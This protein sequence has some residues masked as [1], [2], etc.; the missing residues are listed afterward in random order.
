[1]KKLITTSIIAVLVSFVTTVFS[2]NYPEEYLGL[3][4]DN[5]NLYAVMKL[6]RESKTL[7]D[8]ERGLNDENSRIN[9]LDLNGDNLIDYITVTDYVDGNVHTIVLRA[10]LDRNESQDV[11]IFTVEKFRNGSVEIQLI[12]DEAL[13]GRNY[14][15][16]PIYDETPNPG[17]MGNRASTTNVTLVRTT[18][19]Q[20][21]TW[22]VIRF[23][24][25]PNYVVWRSSWYWGY[26]PVSWR[27]WRP[28]YWHYYYG[29]HYNWYHD[30]YVHYRFWSR[31]RY[32]NYN[33]YYISIRTQSPRVYS[34]I[35]EG[36][37]RETYSRPE[38]R[39]EGEI[40]FTKMHPTQ[41]RRTAENTPVVRNLNSSRERNGEVAKQGTSVQSR[42]NVTTRERTT[43]RNIGT[44][45][46]TTTTARDRTQER[47]TSQNP[48][49]STRSTT[50][51]AERNRDLATGKNTGTAT[52]TTTARDRTQERTT[53]QNPGTTTRTTTARERTQERT[54]SQNPGI[55]TRST[56]ATAERNRDLATGRN[57]GTTARST[58]TRVERERST[59]VAQNKPS[60]K[61]TIAAKPERS[62][63]TQAPKASSKQSS[64]RIESR[65]NA[66]TSSRVNSE[67]RKR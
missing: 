43:D 29:Y 57:T 25:M 56:T 54:T 20:V 65:Q 4:G 23:I 18:T 51:T 11:A 40:L 12:G 59:S 5:L 34:R 9:N 6:F 16:E 61:T 3:P 17:Y 28:Y 33:T 47:T 32:T 10:L 27:P 1:M 35:K 60:T 46:R 67:T 21:A 66:N 26:Y 37:Y 38:Q 39:R 55:S 22:P 44:S 53:S 31:P 58:T 48:G 50:A 45:T 52:R 8:F 13:Y 36:S 64:S 63:N 19:Y 62:R 30:Y 14:I 49:I 42:A 41:T 24:F 15:I 2:Q 7:E